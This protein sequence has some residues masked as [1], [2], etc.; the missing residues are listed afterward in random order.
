MSE[1]FQAGCKLI[2][3]FV[4]EKH[5]ERWLQALRLS[6][7][8]L[9][10]QHVLRR[11]D[12]EGIKDLAAHHCECVGAV[13]RGRHIVSSLPDEVDVLAIDRFGIEI[14]NL[15]KNASSRF[16][17]R[18]A[19]SLRTVGGACDACGLLARS[20]RARPTRIAIFAPCHHFR[21]AGINSFQWRSIADCRLTFTSYVR[22]GFEPIIEIA[23]T[24]LPRRQLLKS[25]SNSHE[26]KH[27]P[28]GV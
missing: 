18:I 12:H 19:F 2:T 28:C 27:R 9:N 11:I 26:T 1:F 7:E 3:P 15:R 5:R 10:V 8:V 25:T 17:S 20:G 22:L 14:E 21:Q 4:S 6:G 16:S 24:P 23:T 13:A